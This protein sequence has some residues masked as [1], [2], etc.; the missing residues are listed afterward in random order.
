MK[1][2]PQGRY[3]VKLAIILGYPTQY[4]WRKFQASKLKIQ[5]GC[6]VDAKKGYCKLDCEALSGFAET[7]DLCRALFQQRLPQFET[8]A[9]NQP[10][11]KDFMA[12][13]LYDEDLRDHPEIVEFAL[14]EAFL[15]MSTQYLGGV[16]V[17]R[18]ISM[19]Y[20]N[21]REYEDLI[22]SQL[23]HV[24]GDDIKQLKF[25]INLH[26]VQ[27]ELDG[28]FTFLSAEYTAKFLQQYRKRHGALP[29]SNRYSDEEVFQDFMPS[30]LQRGIGKTGEGLA[31]DTSRCLHYGSRIAPGHFRLVLFLQ[32]VSY[33]NIAECKLNTIDHRRFFENSPRNLALKPRISYPF[34]HHYS[35]PLGK[36]DSKSSFQETIQQ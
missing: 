19:L 27:D 1:E 26:D 13:L 5:A 24:D 17:L 25:F 33:H 2:H 15:A 22:R 31:V 16:P 23:F 21:H 8:I 28:P 34:A 14:N 20:S 36:T 11:G 29:A 9:A 4:I 6:Q 10:T 18:R 35:N 32:Y 3:L 7:L 12:D 30:T